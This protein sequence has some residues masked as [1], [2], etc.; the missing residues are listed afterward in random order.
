[1]KT[2]RLGFPTAPKQVAA[3]R[4]AGRNDR[5]VRFMRE[6]RLWCGSNKELI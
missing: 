5:S 2:T 3:K 4:R 1:M 6:E